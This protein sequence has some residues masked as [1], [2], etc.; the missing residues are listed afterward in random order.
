MQLTTTLN[1]IREHGPCAEGWGK[2]LRHLGKTKADDEPVAFSTILESNGIEDAIWCCRVEPQHSREW[3]L[4]AVE[5]AGQVQHLMADP[6]SIA[7]LD[8]ARKYALGEASDADLSAAWDAAW[9][10]QA[11]IFLRIVG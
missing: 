10:E 1:R 7:A 11:G 8:V 2:L 4:F 9:R 5:C 3:R 6:R